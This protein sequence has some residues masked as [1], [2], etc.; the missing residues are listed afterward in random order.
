MKKLPTLVIGAA[1]A[2]I[3]LP[4]HAAFKI[5]VT[6]SGIIQTTAERWAVP[7]NNAGATIRT[8]N[9]PSAKAMVLHYSAVCLALGGSFGWVDIDIVVNGTTVAPTVGNEDIFCSTDS[10][11]TRAAI[12]VRIQGI[13]GN[14][15]VQIIGNKRTGVTYMTLAT[16]H[17]WCLTRN[18]F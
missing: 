13:A 14:N 18:A 16:R 2:A 12:T 17:C 6:R 15:T 3:A 4:A 8:F 10:G 5:S 1:L 11:Y 9:L 7:L